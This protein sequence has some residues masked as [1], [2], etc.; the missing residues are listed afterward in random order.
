MISVLQSP[1]TA[2]SQFKFSIK[3]FYSFPIKHHKGR[4]GKM[5]QRLKAVCAFNQ[6]WL[7]TQNCM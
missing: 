1:D 7:L 3:L 2:P 4:T 6:G 5:V